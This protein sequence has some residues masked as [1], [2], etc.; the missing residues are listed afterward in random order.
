RVL[1]AQS[2]IESAPI[3]GRD[4]ALRIFGTTLVW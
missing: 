2:V 4:E 1:A 3:V